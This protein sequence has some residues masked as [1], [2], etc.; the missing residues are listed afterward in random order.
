MI[1]SIS[2]SSLLLGLGKFGESTSLCLEIGEV[3]LFLD[4]AFFENVDLA[5]LFNGAHSVRNDDRRSALHGGL[6]S[7]LNFLL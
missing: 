5:A 4:L 7:F 2:G 3:T 1:M 6:D